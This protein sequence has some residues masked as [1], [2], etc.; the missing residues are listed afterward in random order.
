[1]INKSIA[2]KL[3]REFANYKKNTNRT[4][5]FLAFSH[6]LF[7]ST[8]K[9]RDYRWHLPATR[10]TRILQARCEEFPSINENAGWQFFRTTTG[11]QQG[12]DV[13][14][15]SRL[16]ITFS[17]NF[18]VAEILRSF[19]LVLDGNA[20]KEILESSRLLFLEKILA[21]D[22]VLSNAEYNKSVSLNKWIIADLP[23]LRILLAIC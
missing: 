22:F 11:I 19:K 5:A 1:M 10:K 15:K 20:D 4:I 21:N 18:G 8:L 7:H 3:F 16:V 17:T 14:D 23:L 13:F 9:W 2:Y 6:S 12:L